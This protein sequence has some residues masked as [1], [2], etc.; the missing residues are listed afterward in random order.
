VHGR[1][2]AS[3]VH[4][5]VLRLP[6]AYGPG[7]KGNM[8]KLF[9]AVRHG[10]PLPLSNVTNRRSMV[11]SGN[12]A[13]AVSSVLRAPRA[14]GETFFV[15][16]GEDLS[17]PELLRRVGVALGKAPKMFPMPQSILGT[18]GRLG[19]LIGAVRPLPINSDVIHRLVGSLTVDISKLR[20]LTGYEPPFSIQ[21]A[22]RETALWYESR[23]F[24]T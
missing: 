12:V 3:G 24:K 17:T 23:Y 20:A 9:D 10:V 1:G 13:A 21:T 14:N 19:D 5:S 2:V 4:T 22:L 16:D 18:V 7:M 8:V 6:L 11:F 15:S